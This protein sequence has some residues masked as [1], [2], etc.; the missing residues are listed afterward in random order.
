MR[1]VGGRGSNYAPSTVSVLLAARL[2][3]SIVQSNGG[4][5]QGAFVIAGVDTHKEG[6]VKGRREG[7]REAEGEREGERGGG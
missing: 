7:E 6:E 5:L 1:G 2:F 3:N 4:A